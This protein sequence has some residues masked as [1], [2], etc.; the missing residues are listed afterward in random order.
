MIEIIIAIVIGVV[1]GLINGAAGTAYGMSE[2]NIVGRGE[3][4][5]WDFIP[6]E[7]NVVFHK[8]SD[9]KKGL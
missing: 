6:D 5:A 7:R 4:I 2:S 8:K 3:G 1:L 9:R